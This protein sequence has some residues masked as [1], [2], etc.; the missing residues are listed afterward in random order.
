[1]IIFQCPCCWCILYDFF[2]KYNI[3]VNW[4]YLI[5]NNNSAQHFNN[6]FLV[7]RAWHERVQKYQWVAAYGSRHDSRRAFAERLWGRQEVVI[8][9]SLPPDSIFSLSFTR[10]HTKRQLTGPRRA[11]KA[12]GRRTL[13]HLS[14]NNEYRCF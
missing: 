2:I 5:F 12:G 6:Y 14:P 1:M 4:K 10:I 9:A 7:L 8:I 3:F 11:T 13:Q